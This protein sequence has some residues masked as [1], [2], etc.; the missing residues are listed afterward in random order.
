MAQKVPV[1]DN[2][3]SIVYS[4]PWS[5]MSNS[6]SFDNSLHLATNNGASA[7][8]AF[9][10]VSVNIVGSVS[11]CTTSGAPVS[12][13][14]ALNRAIVKTAS[15]A[16]TTQIQNN[17]LFYS[18]GTL[19]NTEHLVSLINQGSGIPL[20]LDLFA[21]VTQLT[22]APIGG[23]PATTGNPSHVLPTTASADGST[24]SSGTGIGTSSASGSSS[25]TG[26][27]SVISSRTPSSASANA[28]T[29]STV[30]MLTTVNGV[31]TS[32]PLVTTVFAVPTAIPGG[33]NT[34]TPPSSGSSRSHSIGPIV[35]A[36]IAAAVVV[37]LLLLL[38]LYCRRRRRRNPRVDAPLHNHSPEILTPFNLDQTSSREHAESSPTETHSSSAPPQLPTTDSQTELAGF[39]SEKR[40]MPEEGPSSSSSLSDLFS[41]ESSP[42]FDEKRA[43]GPSSAVTRDSSLNAPPP[44]LPRHSTHPRP[45]SSISPS[46]AVPAYFRDT[47][48]GRYRSGIP[49][50]SDR[51]MSHILD[52]PPS[53]DSVRDADSR[54]RPQASEFLTTTIDASRL[55]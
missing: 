19:A 53:Y 28:T 23:G 30:M 21:Y 25:S 55:V 7:S 29:V 13:Q 31:A 50:L 4:G 43:S 52:T 49:T 15:I 10:G 17:V 33:T 45:P 18:S 38:L 40:H 5:P 9:T 32:L 42:L 47:D 8:L 24:P 44:S 37:I 39:P 11:P 54:D 20:M 3:G 34:N 51:R 6:G 27:S 46:E 2:D 1:D 41:P 36:I 14:V 12:F 16:C 48:T 22:P 35:G 26:G